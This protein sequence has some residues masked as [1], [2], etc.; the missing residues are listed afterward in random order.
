MTTGQYPIRSSAS[1]FYAA[2]SLASSSVPRGSM[3]RGKQQL[4]ALLHSGVA[5]KGPLR[6]PTLLAGWGGAA[7]LDARC[8]ARLQ[9]TAVGPHPVRAAGRRF[10]LRT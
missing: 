8:F 9:G 5:L 10:D 6:A 2:A 1:S 7:H 3:P 4:T